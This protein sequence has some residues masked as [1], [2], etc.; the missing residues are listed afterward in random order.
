MNLIIVESPTKANTIKKFL[1]KEY[2]VKAS[3]GHIRDL[4]KSKLGV[5]VKNSF[6]PQYIIPLKA[7]KKISELKQ[8]LEKTPEVILATDEDREGE[9]IAFH[10]VKAL[11]LKNPKRIVFHE[12]TEAAIKKALKNPREI[13]MNLVN[14]QQARRILDRLVGYKLSPLLWKKVVRGLSAGRVQSVALRLIA[15]REK[16]IERFKPEEYWLI[17][18]V[19]RK[20]ASSPEFEARLVGKNGKTIGKQ[21]IKTKKEAEEIIKALKGAECYI[22]N[23]KKST[24]KKNPL[25]P[26]TTSSLQQ[27]AWQK[28][29]F[30]AKATMVIAQNLYERGFITYHRTDSLNLSA[31]SLKA[32]E[33]F[34]LKSFGK[35]YWAERLYKTK[36]KTAQEAHEAIRPVD[37]LKLPDTLKTELELRQ[38]KLYDL[39][40]RRF[41]ASQMA[42]A[43][44][45]SSKIYIEAI[46]KNKEAKPK[47]LLFRASGQTLKFDGFTKVYSLKIEE[48]VLP[49]LKEGEKVNL[50]KAVPSQHFT[51]PPARYNDASLIKVLEKEGIGRPSTY[52]VII[53]TIQKR[54]YAQKGKDKRFRPTEIGK[55]VNS[56]LT[57][58]F[59][60]IVDIKFTAKMEEELDEIA[61]G[62]KE[63][64]KVLNDFY[65]PFEKNLMQKEKEITKKNLTE[66][67]DK[68]CPKCGASLLIRW[69]RFGKFCACSNFPNCKYTESLEKPKLGIKCPK[70][71]SG[72]IVE[73]R[74][75]KGKIFY[76]CSRFPECEFALWDKPVSGKKCP[77]CGSLLITDK[78]GNVK[79]SNKE[80]GYI[81]K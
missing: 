46:L 11:G 13:N 14:A 40:W 45:Y 71:G 4:P 26:F 75:R 6:R 57:K 33:K 20:E 76:G 34:I 47:T 79:C 39:I 56:L 1:G 41:I 24:L 17:A 78:K 19:F 27:E 9:A 52:A 81:E 3:Y 59:P 12:I 42:P 44:I 49:E 31:E 68:K 36:S 60:E 35:E 66:K 22:Q 80:C 7:R 10:L 67:T 77:D 30:S 53:D 8:S 2:L 43:E 50:E 51:K 61:R 25:P 73:K 5:D 74:T 21:E 70:C 37:P 72:E 23:I 65:Q 16:E 32:A 15:E 63:W 64:V 54:N 58:H 18:A 62:E 38:L 69:G 55:I 28:L 29:N 48:T